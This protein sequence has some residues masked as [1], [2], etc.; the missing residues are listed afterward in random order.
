[1]HVRSIIVKPATDPHSYEPTPQDARTLADA[2][3][4]IV[5]GVGYDEW[6]AKLLK[7]DPQGGRAVLSVGD[8]LGLKQGENPHRW[9]FPSDVRG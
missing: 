4:A 1:M 2:Q 5:N 8:V 7:A 3:L 9:Y 6:A